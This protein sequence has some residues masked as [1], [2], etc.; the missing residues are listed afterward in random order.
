MKQP[1]PNPPTA[2]MAIHLE[3]KRCDWFLRLDEDFQ[4]DQHE[5]IGGIT[6][7]E[8]IRVGWLPEQAIDSS[9]LARSRKASNP[10][11]AL[12]ARHDLHDSVG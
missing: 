11:M 7:A 3:P 9:R 5:G 1:A 10:L 8:A 4:R 12:P 6:R 2:L